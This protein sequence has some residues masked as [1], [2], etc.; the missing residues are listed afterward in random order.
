MLIDAQHPLSCH[1]LVLRIT[2]TVFYLTIWIIKQVKRSQMLLQSPP[3]EK[4]K[5]ML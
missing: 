5:V 2:I 4:Y 1:I 3:V